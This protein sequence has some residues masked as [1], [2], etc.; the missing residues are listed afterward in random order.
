MDTPVS[1]T[2]Q[3]G[4]ET[5]LFQFE[6]TAGQRLFLDNLGNQSGGGNQVIGSQ[7]IGGFER[8]FTIP[9]DGNYIVAVR[10]FGETP[11]NYQFRLV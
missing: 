3:P 5:N 7:T 9:A 4:T 11:L 2:L 1:G 8:E 10:G 6:A